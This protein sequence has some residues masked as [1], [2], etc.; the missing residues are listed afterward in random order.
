MEWT[1]KD[2]TKGTVCSCLSVL[3]LTTEY[4]KQ[5]RK[6]AK[7]K[8]WNYPSA[9]SH[10]QNNNTC[11]ISEF[12]P[13]SHHFQRF[14]CQMQT[15]DLV[16]PRTCSVPVKS[17]SSLQIGVRR[18]KKEAF[19]PTFVKIDISID[20]SCEY[21]S[22]LMKSASVSATLVGGRLGGVCWCC[23]FCCWIL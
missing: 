19:F 21:H 2:T 22:K 8:V 12:P 13:Q 16:D 14:L 4:V 6:K 18:G 7:G 9:F 20:I 3:G 17:R 11:N 23:V 5:K 15:G 10:K 1:E